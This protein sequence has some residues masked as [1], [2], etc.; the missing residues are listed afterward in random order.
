METKTSGSAQS[1]LSHGCI[2]GRV[3]HGRGGL[4]ARKPSW[5][6]ASAGEKRK[7]VAEEIHR[8]EETKMY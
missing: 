5:G 7:M 3:Q 8:Q 2:M 1:A 4:D 6:K